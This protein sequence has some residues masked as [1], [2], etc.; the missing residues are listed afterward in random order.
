MFHAVSLCG[1][2]AS[3]VLL[4]A[5]A[6]L[7]GCGYLGAGGGATVFTCSTANCFLADGFVLTAPIQK[8]VIEGIRFEP[9]R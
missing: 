9:V 1:H 6:R 3:T 8:I 4:Y 2:I 7:L 5:L